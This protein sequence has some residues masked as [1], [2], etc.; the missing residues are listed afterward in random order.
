MSE[1]FEDFERRVQLLR[2]HG[3]SRGEEIPEDVAR[4]IVRKLDEAYRRFLNRLKQDEAL[5]AAAD[6]IASEAKRRNIPV[7]LETVNLLFQNPS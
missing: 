5:L 7:N 2:D 4:L 6:H 1:P 3:E